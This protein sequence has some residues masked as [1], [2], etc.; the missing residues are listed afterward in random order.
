ME[1]SRGG[2]SRSETSWSETERGSQTMVY[3]QT[4]LA[5]VTGTSMKLLGN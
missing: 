4:R 5:R 3:D 1:T 2:T